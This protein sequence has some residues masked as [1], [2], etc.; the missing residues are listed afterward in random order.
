MNAWAEVENPNICYKRGGSD[1]HLNLQSFGSDPY[2]GQGI[3]AYNG[4]LYSVMDDVL[5]KN[6]STSYAT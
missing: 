2:T 3:F 6:A 5:I 1:M 4:D